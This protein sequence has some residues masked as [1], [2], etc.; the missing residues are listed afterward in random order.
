M[1]NRIRL[2]YFTS[3]REIF[4]DE[5]VSRTV[6]DPDTGENYGYRTGNLE[7]IAL[8]LQKDE[9]DFARNFELA[10]VFSDDADAHV[11]AARKSV[12]R[13]P[14]DVRVPAEG[15]KG[16]MVL[17]DLL[18]RISSEPWRK[19]KHKEEK[20]GAKAE[21][22]REIVREMRKR[23]VDILISDS[24][25]SL[26]GPVMLSAYGKRNLNIHPAITEIN[27]PYR[28]PGLT[29]TRDAL[30]RAKFGYIIIDDKKRPE[31]WPEG[32]PIEVEF[33]GKIRQAIKVSRYTLTGVTVHIID[34]QVD[35]GPVVASQLNHISSNPT[36][37]GIRE[38]N[39]EI[40][41][42]LLPI[43]LFNYVIRPDVH[44]IIKEGK[45]VHAQTR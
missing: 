4:L 20:A 33:R 38:S 40:K 37:E 9:S 28:L 27:S 1:D 45:Q 11:E 22:E 19:I 7:A 42:R 35:H 16:G 41:R 32:E 34:A 13:W 43:A 30:T 8:E 29:P 18:V 2:A 15:L 31:T 6:M 39:Y 14:F 21:Y 36:Y 24:H 23:G 44:A 5:Q 3:F 25:L 26:I 12:D 17:D 10:M